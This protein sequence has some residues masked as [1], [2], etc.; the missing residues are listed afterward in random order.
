MCLNFPCN[1]FNF[2][3]YNFFYI[4]I[5]FGIFFYVLTCINYSI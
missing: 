3:Y 1:F 4:F 2:T 5:I